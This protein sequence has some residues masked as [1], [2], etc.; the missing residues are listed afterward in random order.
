[1]KIEFFFDCSSPWTYLAFEAIQPLAAEFGADLIWRPILV[2]GIFN[3]INPTA[4][5]RNRPPSP[6]AKSA[7]VRKDIGDWEKALGVTIR[8]LPTGHPVNSVKV[9]RACMVL[10]DSAPPKL[11]GFAR[12]AFQA[13]FTDDRDLSTDAV[14]EDL[15]RQA[16]LDPAGMFA[17]IG[18][19]GV[20]D[21]LRRNVDE[22][23]ARG[24][25]GSPTMYLDGDDMYFGVDRIQLLRLA[26]ERKAAA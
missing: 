2:G 26:M 13:Y 16:D 1:M 3:A 6:A 7:Y 5:I 10:L 25:F 8:F 18:E 23:M 9:M 17:K 19:Q 22:A 14:V 24:A 15:F 20:K 11:V 4:D 21:A 12:S